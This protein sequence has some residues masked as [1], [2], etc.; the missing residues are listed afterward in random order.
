MLNAARQ[1]AGDLGQA[2]GDT[3]IRV[4]DNT[5]QMV[6]P[7]ADKVLT[8]LNVA[9]QYQAD[10]VAKVAVLHALRRNASQLPLKALAL[11]GETSKR[12]TGL[13]AHK[14]EGM[15]RQ[16]AIQT[17]VGDAPVFYFFKRR[18]AVTCW[19]S[20]LTPALNRVD[21]AGIPQKDI[22]SSKGLSMSLDGLAWHRGTSVIKTPGG[23]R[24]LT[25]LQS[26][27]YPGKHYYFDRPL[28]A[29]ETVGIIAQ[30]PGHDPTSM[31]GFIG[32]VGET[33]TMCVPWTGVK[34][35]LIKSRIMYPPKGT[36]SGA[37]PPRRPPGY[38]PPRAHEVQQDLRRAESAA[39]KT[40]Q[41]MGRFQNKG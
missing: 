36:Q 3:L 18:V 14:V 13:A 22:I 33:E 40:A 15:A 7:A 31:D 21:T 19:K 6:A 32:Q 12:A 10:T 26:L 38:R 35:K 5:N 25:H 20:G 39:V 1:K 17:V 28:S 11:A 41:V 23:T 37:R 2:T 27:S 8:G 30:Q 9:H 16:D 34:S 29:K 4:N 24:T